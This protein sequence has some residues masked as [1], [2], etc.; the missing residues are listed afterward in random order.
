MDSIRQDLGVSRAKQVSPVLSWVHSR[1]S[2][3][4]KR[5]EQDQTFVVF[6]LTFRC[7]DQ[8][9]LV[10]DHLRRDVQNWLSPPD[11]STNHNF[12][13]KARHSGTAGWFFESNAITEWKARGSL[14]W[15][16]GKR[17]FFEPQR[18]LCTNDLLILSGGRE[19][20]SS[21][22]HRFLGLFYFIHSA[23]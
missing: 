13:R 8:R 7:R 10:G 4:V 18:V 23:H 20:H 2:A 1:S 3:N 21:V 17:M 14:L 16:H 15:I 9:Y 11:P 5:N 19:K 22:C 12:V 6:L